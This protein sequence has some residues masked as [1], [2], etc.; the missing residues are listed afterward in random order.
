MVI[1]DQASVD[2]FPS[3]LQRSSVQASLTKKK[4]IYT[5]HLVMFD[6]AGATQS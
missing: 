3:D 4:K 2:Y 1:F 6:T 5:F